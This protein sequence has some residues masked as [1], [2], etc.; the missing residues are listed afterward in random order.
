[1]K[2]KFEKP[3]TESVDGLDA[4]SF[5]EVDKLG[6][7][8]EHICYHDDKTMRSCIRRKIGK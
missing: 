1:M 7:T 3:T 8:H 6:A 4:V 2:I 5:A